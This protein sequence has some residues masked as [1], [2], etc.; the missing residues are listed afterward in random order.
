M[1]TRERPVD[2]GTA[3]AR[4]LLADLGGEIRTARRDRGLS[5]ETIGHAIGV[6]GVTVGRIERGLARRASILHVAQL[7]ETVGLELS[8]RAF[9]GGRPIRDAAQVA[10]LGRFKVGLHGS[11]RWRTEVPLPIPGDQRAWDA[12]IIGTGWRFGVEVE[13]APRDAQALVRRL[14]LKARDARVDGVILVLPVTRRTRA[15]LRETDATLMPSLPGRSA[16]TLELLRAGI[17][18]PDSAIVCV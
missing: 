5:Q 7:L 11:L 15:F 14:A 6:S 2:R 18:P 4:K 13:S 9:P 8:A 1:P 3:R 10:L 17:R 12:M 16:R